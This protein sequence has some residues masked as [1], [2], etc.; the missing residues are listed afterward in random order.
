MTI[1]RGEWMPYLASSP[2]R[3]AMTPE[4]PAVEISAMRRTILTHTVDSPVLG[5]SVPPLLGVIE[6]ANSL[7]LEALK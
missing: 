3:L 1:M 6:I 5:E 2:L 4:M 7:K